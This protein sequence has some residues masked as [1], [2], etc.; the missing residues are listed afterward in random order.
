MIIFPYL[1]C[2]INMNKSNICGDPKTFK[3][4]LLKKRFLWSLRVVLLSSLIHCCQ[5]DPR[6]LIHF[7][8][9][10]RIFCITYTYV[11][12]HTN[13]RIPFLSNRSDKILTFASRQTYWLLSHKKELAAVAP[14]TAAQNHI[15]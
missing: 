13:T 7:Y 1:P 8:D 3:S 12:K 9:N 5:T 11:Q 4:T 2:T 10:F 6:V 15:K 14:H